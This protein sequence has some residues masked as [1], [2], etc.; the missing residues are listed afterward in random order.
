MSATSAAPDGAAPSR[1]PAPAAP[2]AATGPRPRVLSTAEWVGFMAMVFGMFMAILDIQIVA[3][4]ISEIQAGL[5]ASP[6]EASWIQTSYLIAE[7]VM[8]PL[9]GF[10]SR[11]LSTRVLFTISAAG[12]TLFSLACAFASS[13]EAMIAFRA[14]QGFIGGAMIP[15]VFATVFL[16]FQGPRKVTMSVVIGLTVT[17]APTIGPTLGGWITQQLSWHWL[18][19]L[20]VPI[21]TAIALIVWSTMQV[22]RADHSLFARFDWWGL[23]GMATFLGS[24]EYVMEEGPRWDWLADPTIATFSAIC[25]AS[26]LFFFWHSLT[27]RDPIVELRAYGNRNFAIGSLFSFILGVGLYGSVYIIPLF[28]GRVRGYDSMQ[29][30][31]TMAITGACMFLGAPIS[32][33]LARVLDLRLM[34]AIGLGLTG[35]AVWMTA[36]LTAQSSF[37]EL[38]LPLGLRG[39]AMMFVMLPVNQ[40]A[41]GTL[42]PA[43]VKNASGLYNLTR[44]LGGAIGLAAINTVAQDRSFLHRVQL[45]EMAGWARPGATQ[46]LDT[47]TSAISR[48]VDSIDAE[49]AALR[50]MYSVVQREAL[51]MAYNDVLV[52]MALLF[53]AAIPLVLLLKTPPAAGGGGGDAH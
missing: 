39:F 32:G 38:A 11:L 47:V 6:D 28:L 41:L 49:A 24:L 16:L 33:R 20:N 36:G 21:G 44:N 25:A 9:S 13:L 1:A 35:L 37:A 15:T 5:A 30:G 27:R 8:I 29:I 2:L 19:F 46:F 10:L 51:I 23:A 48:R 45:G 50:R 43:M 4:S 53:F 18:F 34:L 7:I 22:D 40:V 3:S 14:L 31:E 42:P 17:L 52:L 26:G 12:F